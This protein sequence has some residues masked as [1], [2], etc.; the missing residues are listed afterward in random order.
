MHSW[1]MFNRT[2]YHHRQIHWHKATIKL[3]RVRH[4]IQFL[5]VSTN[6]KLCMTNKTYKMKNMMAKWHTSC[7]CQLFTSLHH[8]NI[9]NENHTNCTP[10]RITQLRLWLVIS[11]SL[12]GTTASTYSASHRSTSCE[13]KGCSC[14][15]SDVIILIIY[16]FHCRG[17]YLCNR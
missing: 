9:Y 4:V 11:T 1:P 14:C 10:N 12:N 3:E 7:F 5:Y 17:P 15:C 8:I 6:V 16:L 2:A 13:A